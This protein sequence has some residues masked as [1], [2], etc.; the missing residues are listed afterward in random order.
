MSPGRLP[1]RAAVLGG[2]LVV[3][4]LLRAW[5]AASG[6]LLWHPDEIFMVLYPLNLFSGDLNPH[7]FYYPSWHFYELGLLYG[8]DFLWH[9]AVDGVG[10]FD[11][12]ARHFFVDAT[13]L[14]DLAR[15]LAV[16]YG[17]GTVLLAGAIAGRLAAG[18]DVAQ[19]PAR[20]HAGG[21]HRTWGNLLSSPALL[22][23]AS[24]AV[25]SVH[26]RQSPLATVDT[27][28]AFWFAAATLAAL[29][30]LDTARRRDYLLAGVLVGVA[31]ATKYPG[32]AAGGAVLAAH[33]LTRRSLRD[34]RLWLAGGAAVA[35]FG[36]L[37]PYVLLDAST[38]LEHFRFQ[39][40]HVEAG[41]F[42]DAPAPWAALV[43]GLRVGIGTPAWLLWLGVS[44]WAL[45]RRR[46]AHAVVLATFLAGYVAVSW[47]D[48]SFLRYLLPLLPLQAALVGDGLARLGTGLAGQ[49]SQRRARFTALGSDAQRRAAVTMLATALLLLAPARAALGVAT[50][51]ARPDTRTQA[52][53]WIERHVPSGTS[54]CNFGG[55]PGDVP[56][57]TYEDQWWRLRTFQAAWP[58]GAQARLARALAD[59]DPGVPFYSQAVRN[60]N[61]D[62]ESGSVELIHQR[63]CALVITHEHPLPYSTIA[64]D[65]ARRVPEEATRVAR[66]DPHLDPDLDLRADFDADDAYYLPL[67]G[68]GADR[69]GP[70]V[71]LWQVDAYRTAPRPT[72]MR[73]VFSRVLSL[74]A[75]NA[76]LASDVPAAA[77]ALRAATAFHPDNRHAL[78][79]AAHLHRARGDTTAARTAF[80]QLLTREPASSTA[81]EGLAA[82][83]AA[84]GD[85]AEAA[86]WMAEVCR[87]RPRD[88][89]AAR[90][91]QIWQQRTADVSSARD[92]D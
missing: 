60:D 74:M 83:A 27:P 37:S 64:A 44:G 82:L 5:G 21:P 49:V 75:A 43:H 88:E 50:L 18:D 91:W 42:G 55:W 17:V 78:L 10:L 9:R 33:L 56:L 13:P 16:L 38:F 81:R 23:A 62:V 6:E 20:H 29:R 19:K 67:D 24:L 45:W 31:A 71:D 58:A 59:V 41:R 14:R 47:G 39:V 86:K 32:A 3:A 57:R 30:L 63:Q 52:R 61:R 70:R 72:S 8:A 87:L 12:I 90:Q 68:R 34:P 2:I 51:S 25:N 79:V 65:V 46:A 84:R 15:G 69:P 85:Y 36:C 66:F 80:E 4:G 89:A 7:L 22:A 1:A 77:E 11:W 53:E 35:A 76:L 54:I 73:H 40:A 26:V 48:L 28:L 92:A